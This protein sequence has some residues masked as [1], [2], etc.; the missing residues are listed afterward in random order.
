MN[1]KL[2]EAIYNEGAELTFFFD[3]ELKVLVDKIGTEYADEGMLADYVEEHKEEFPET[4]GLIKND[5]ELYLKMFGKYFDSYD[6][7]FRTDN[8]F[9]DLKESS[10]ARFQ[11]RVRESYD[12]STV[13]G[14]AK[15][16]KDIASAVLDGKLYDSNAVL[17]ICSMLHCNEDYAAE[18]LDAWIETEQ[19]RRSNLHMTESK[20]QLFE[21]VVHMKEVS[22]NQLATAMAKRLSQYD[23]TDA[24]AQEL[25][26][27][28]KMHI[29]TAVGTGT[30]G[31]QDDTNT[32]LYGNC[33]PANKACALACVRS[34]NP[35]AAR[36]FF[37]RY[38][39]GLG[40]DVAQVEKA[41][42]IASKDPNVSLSAAQQQAAA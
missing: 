2:F 24:G 4:Y 36:Q 14:L 35:Q 28:I 26:N 38:G 27:F 3:R 11:R 33:T 20:K 23:G 5:Y 21:E 7:I 17:A 25:G 41:I 29:G 42:E 18:C 40:I 16:S 6:D 19:I 30:N 39:K 32:Q 34:K 8:H 9:K 22:V 15:Y 12:V 10:K 37:A 13:E 31:I 1:K